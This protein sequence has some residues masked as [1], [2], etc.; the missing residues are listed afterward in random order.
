MGAAQPDS[1][2]HGKRHCSG[3]ETLLA[4]PW[5]L[6]SHSGTPH[7][8]GRCRIS[9]MHARGAAGGAAGCRPELS[10][11]RGGGRL[12]APAHPLDVVAGNWR[13]GGRNRRLF[14]SPSSRRRYD[15]IASLLDHDLTLKAL[16]GIFLV[17][18][19]SG[20]FRSDPELLAAFSLRS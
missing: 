9:L 6:V 1:R 20:Q 12:R 15:V 8:R 18:A 14:L 11:L 19:L 2:S 17:K 13:R 3:G 10:Y 5:S 4:G 7:C 16:I